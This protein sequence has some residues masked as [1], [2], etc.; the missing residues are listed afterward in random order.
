ML[1]PATSQTTI[2]RICIAC[3][4][5]TARDTLSEYVIP[6]TCPWQQLLHENAPQNYIIRTLPVLLSIKTGGAS[7]NQ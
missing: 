6:N 1:E 3:W 4:V 2:G 7:S 5:P